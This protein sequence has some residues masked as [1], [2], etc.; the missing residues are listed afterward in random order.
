MTP[1]LLLVLALG[2][3]LSAA[4]WLAKGPTLYR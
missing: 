4:Y 2:A 1:T 3:L